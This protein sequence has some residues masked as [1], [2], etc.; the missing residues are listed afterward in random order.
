MDL[1]G[2]EEVDSGFLVA[3]YYAFTVWMKPCTGVGV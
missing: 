2:A 1:V 3:C